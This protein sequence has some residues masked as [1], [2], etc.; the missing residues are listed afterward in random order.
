MHGCAR[1]LYVTLAALRGITASPAYRTTAAAK[2]LRSTSGTDHQ[3]FRTRGFA[4]AGVTE[5]YASGDTTPHY[6]AATDTVGTVEPSYHALAVRLVTYVVARELGAAPW[7]S[8]REALR[9]M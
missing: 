1:A 5:E 7:G 8:Q 2:R 6:H 4:A 3:S 9:R